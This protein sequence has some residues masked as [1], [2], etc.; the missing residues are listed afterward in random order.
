MAPPDTSAPVEVLALVARLVEE[1]AGLH[2]SADNLA[3]FAEKAASRAGEVGF[4][5]LLDY[6]YFLRYDPGGGA[7]L[8]A[9]VNALVVHETYFFREE[10]PVRV[11]VREV[12]APIVRAGGR[13]R[14]WCAACATGEEPLTL[15]VML[16]EEHLLGGVEIV[17]SDVSERAL[18]RARGGV[19]WRRSLRALP[20]DAAGWIAV[21]GDRGTVRPDL[22]AAV[23]WAQVNLVDP[24]SV[25]ALGAFDVILCRN[26]LIYFSDATVRSVVAT[27]AGALRPDGR[28]LVGVSESLLRF[29]TLLRCEERGGSFF[30]VKGAP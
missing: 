28:L 1:R 8:D 21:E 14:V 13:A 4:E 17:A 5:S 12:I 6:Y 18:A 16:A 24:A 7:E 2:Y 11:A 23:R 3:I 19:F 27:M 25:M 26:V 10:A 30:Y 20:P 22:V 29:G 15:A 9:L